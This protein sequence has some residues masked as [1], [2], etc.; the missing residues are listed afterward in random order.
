VAVGA[1]ANAIGDSGDQVGAKVADA[2]LVVVLADGA[3]VSV[4]QAAHAG[5][6]HVQIGNF[7]LA[8]EGDPIEDG[9]PVPRHLEVGTGDDEFS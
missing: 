4:E 6:S 1:A 5:R 2:E 3:V 8:F 9:V 7:V